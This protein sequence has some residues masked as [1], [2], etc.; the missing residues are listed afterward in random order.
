MQVRVYEVDTLRHLT[1]ACYVQYAEQ[2]RFACL[3]AAGVSVDQLLEDGIGP[4][5]LQTTIRHHKELVM[6]DEVDVSLCWIWCQG[7]TFQVRTEMRRSDGELAAEV[8]YVS[9]LLDLQRRRLVLDPARELG[10]RAQNP[11]LLGLSP[12][13]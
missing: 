12:I 11:V 10:S 13:A 1:G 2:C 7:K 9:G 6:G 8:E 3:R 4:V 5:N